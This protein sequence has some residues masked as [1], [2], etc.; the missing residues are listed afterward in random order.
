M[1]GKT[2]ETETQRKVL[3]GAVQNEATGQ[4]MNLGLGLA[5]ATT[6]GSSIGGMMGNMK[7][8]ANAQNEVAPQGQNVSPGGICPNCSSMVPQN[9]L[10]CPHCGTK[11]KLQNN[12]V[13]A[14]CGNEVP[15]GS[16]FCPAC[17]TPFVAKQQEIFCTTCGAKNEPNAKFCSS[18]GSKIGG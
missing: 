17:G 12:N 18:C 6:I 16:K 10:F 5:Y 2:Y 14:K 8:R 11:I 1:Y 4:A 7:D 13:C 15:T 9:S 3:E